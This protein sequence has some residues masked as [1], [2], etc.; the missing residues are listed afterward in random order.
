MDDKT[1]DRIYNKLDR[2]DDKLDDH[3]SSTNERMSELRAEIA[4]LKVKSGFWGVIGG[5]FA[6]VLYIIKE[7]L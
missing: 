2:L 6:V 4:A 7:K 3:N 5:L 1:V